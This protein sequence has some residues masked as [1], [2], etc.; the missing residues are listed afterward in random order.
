M[1]EFPAGKCPDK[2]KGQSLKLE[3]PSLNRTILCHIFVTLQGSGVGI[4]LLSSSLSRRLKGLQERA[5]TK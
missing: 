4:S 1:I 5:T 3:D 2:Q